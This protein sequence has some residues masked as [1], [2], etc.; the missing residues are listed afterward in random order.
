MNKYFYPALFHKAEV[1]GFWI[2]FP[3]FPEC[4]TQGDDMEESYKMAVDAL[5]LCLTD[6]ER[7]HTP[8]PVPSSPD[9]IALESDTFLVLIEFDM[10]AYKKR[11]NSAA[12]KKTLTIPQWLNEEALALNVNFSQVLQ[13]ALVDLIQKQKA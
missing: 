3:D 1:G 9:K 6:M 5:G 13:E 4:M 12:V 8:F 7:N 11:T 10:L 2:T